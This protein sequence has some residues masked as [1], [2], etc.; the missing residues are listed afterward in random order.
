VTYFCHIVY[1]RFFLR[2]CFFLGFGVFFWTTGISVQAAQPQYQMPFSHTQVWDSTLTPWR[3]TYGVHSDK[4]GLAFDFYAPSGTQTEVYAPASGTLIRGCTVGNATYLAIETPSGDVVRLLHLD[5]RTVPLTNRGDQKPVV[6]G[7]YL[8][9]VTGAG[10]FDS[11]ECH[12]SS[13]DWHVHV[14]W[15][16]KNCPFR[17][18]GYVFDCTGLQQCS[19]VYSVECNKKHLN[20]TFLSSNGAGATDEKCANLLGRSWSL[21]AQGYDARM[22]QVCLKTMGAYDWQNGYTGYVGPY[23]LEKLT[24][25]RA[26][27]AGGGSTA[28]TLSCDSLKTASF[29]IG[30]VGARVSALQTCMQTAGVYAW[31][32]GVTGYFGPYTQGKLVLWSAGVAP[33][34]SAAPSSPR[35]QVLKSWAAGWGLGVSSKNVRDLQQCLTDEGRYQ[36][37]NG[38]TGIFGPYTRSLL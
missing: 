8:G 10:V 5:A 13:D 28:A 21:G 23:T 3:D 38:I 7:E 4:W 11:P 26:M 6:Q 30:E 16:I 18:D 25:A 24:A 37:K 32:A 36:W 27:S 1:M 19:G 14:S 12:L 9:R 15:E 35:C 34:V 17:L 22:L 20:Q 33:T 2:A 31:P 29:S